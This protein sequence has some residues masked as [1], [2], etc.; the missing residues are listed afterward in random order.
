MTFKV[1]K[2]IVIAGHRGNP[3]AFPEN[4]MDSFRSAVELGVDMLETD[5]H[6]S[7]DGKLVLIHDH[8]VD[9]TTDGTGLVR[10]KTFEELEKLNAGT[11]EHPAKIPTLREFLEYCAGVPGL[12][13]DLEM[14]VFRFERS[15]CYFEDLPEDQKKEETMNLRNGFNFAKKVM[16]TGECDLLILDEVLGLV[17]QEVISR[18]E[19]IRFLQSADDETDLIMTGRVCPDEIRQYADQIS[20]VE[21]L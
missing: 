6:V 4:T 3:A 8:E 2:N 21:N 14:K 20:Y 11:A 17:D 13:L 16:A 7:K 18:E 5:I 10:E 1:K 19:F 15:R 9:R 12:L